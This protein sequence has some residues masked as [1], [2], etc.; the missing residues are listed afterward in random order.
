MQPEERL[1]ALLSLHGT[2]GH[3]QP[4]ANGRDEHDGL[5]PLLD[6]ANRLAELAG[7]EPS[8]DFADRLEA[9]VFAQAALLEAQQRSESEHAGGT[10][11]TFPAT[12]P[13]LPDYQLPPQLGDE[14]PTIPGIAWGATDDDA[15]EAD[16]A[17][18][19]PPAA[20]ALR[21]QARWRRLLAP[22]LAATLLLAL[23][24]ATFTAVAAAGPGTPLYSLHRWEQGVQASIAGSAAD[25]TRLHL[26]Y[27]RDALAA[28]D[29]AVVRHETGA[30][31]DDALAT[32]SDEMRAAATN[33]DSVPAGGDHVTLS[34]Q[35]DQ[36][37][38]RGRGDLH[39]AL[40]G[41]P[42]PERVTTTSALAQLGDDVLRVNQVE[43]VYFGHGQHL[44][45]ITVTGS[46]F[47]QGA[48][49]LVNG[50]SAGTVT[51]VTATTLVAQ[52]PSDDS[53]PLPG[54]VGVANPDN[55]AAVTSSISSHEQEN[56]G[57]PTPS[58]DDHGG[59]GGDDGGGDDHGGGSGNSGSG[60]GDNS[61]SGSLGGSGSSGH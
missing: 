17:P 24:T 10:M 40:P 41:L 48:I 6:A 23:G 54:S 33:L 59:H 51:S 46:G 19:R 4:S 28:L 30:T 14:A 25:R 13:T 56:E 43:M 44:W 47:Q 18:P 36:L 45:Q 21:G 8:A 11:A 57:T 35:L 31:Y 16:V 52:L 5:Q 50:Q 58:S 61:G 2:N 39:A 60:G 15:T 22:A 53:A 49:L 3:L 38:A 55:T 12:A 20:M 7:T 37:R 32:F 26:T 34:A 42:W 29:A 9:R 1:D 27:A